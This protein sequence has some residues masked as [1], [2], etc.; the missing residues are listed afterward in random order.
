MA[1]QYK[2]K[3]TG[4]LRYV[5]EALN[6]EEKSLAKRVEVLEKELERLKGKKIM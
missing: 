1:L 5:N 2:D 4:K 3:K 6:D